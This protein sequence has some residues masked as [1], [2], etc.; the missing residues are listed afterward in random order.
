MA[1]PKGN[2]YQVGK[3]WRVKYPMGKDPRTG[4]YRT[5]QETYPTEADAWDRLNRLR[6][7]EADGVLI[8]PSRITVSQFSQRWL[9]AK[10]SSIRESSLIIY[11]TALETLL[12]ELANVPLSKLDA[13][14]LL[15]WHARLL[16]RLKPTTVQRYHHTVR[17]MLRDAVRWGY[18][19]RNVAADVTPPTAEPP[20]L[21]VW[22]RAQIETFLKVIKGTRHEAMWH[23]LMTTGIRVG[24]LCALK[25]DDLFGDQLTIR[26]TASRDEH[27]RVIVH[28]PKTRAGRRVLVL[29]RQTLALL[30]SYKQYLHGQRQRYGD[31]WNAEGWMFPT[32]RGSMIHPQTVRQRLRTVCRKAGL[33]Y[34]G[35]H[36]IR[37]TYGTDMMRAGVSPRV[38]QER[39]GH[40]NVTITLNLY[41]HPDVE[42]HRSVADVIE[43]NENDGEENRS[44]FVAKFS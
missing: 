31:W 12:P 5:I 13:P 3:A 23:L 20:E 7:E 37:H 35:P 30:H 4:K 22:S 10:R 26:R 14:M 33:P 11:Q 1:R 9:A 34:I 41:S 36:G 2:V 29:S 42:M 8:A 39:M 28:E 6:V 44:T 27:G 25:Q 19:S 43:R 16:T 15:A 18:L 21:R 24:E 32:Q 17:S 38:V 40:S